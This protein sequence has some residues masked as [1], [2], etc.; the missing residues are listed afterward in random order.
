MEIRK[1][2]KI[3]GGSFTL[4]IPKQWVDRRKL[5]SGQQM[6]ISEEDDGSL[7]IYP[8]TTPSEKR[9][10]ATLQ[11]EE[12]SEIKALEYTVATYYI[13]GAERIDIISKK[14]IPAELKRKLKLFRLALP[15]VEVSEEG[16]NIIS[17]QALIDPAA[18]RLESLLS[19]TSV[20]SLHLQEDAV[21][22]VMNWDFPLAREVIERSGEALRH[23]RLTIR[24]VALASISRTIAREIGV[25]SLRECVTFALMARDL[26]RLVY[27]CSQI[28]THV[29]SL[30]HEKKVDRKI[31]N[32]MESL[33]KLVYAM[34]EDAVRSFLEKDGKLA[35]QVLLKMSD[36]RK[37][38]ES[39]LKEVMAKVKDADTAVTM[40]LIGRDLRRI[41]GYSVAI[42]D[43][44]MNRILTPS[45]ERTR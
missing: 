22:S 4:S 10:K 27:H 44:G 26:S 19:K 45:S 7:N 25:S 3:K 5:K 36:V 32:S 43:D 8:V 31:L 12:F 35:V 17:F 13:Q 28:A 9:L 21:N 39:L 41:A 24:Q 20:F 14:I 11:L 30:E 34:Q 15:G 2:Q 23:Y 33:S 6:A 38:E 40:G 1:L 18:F 29:L 42:A 37:N 16:A